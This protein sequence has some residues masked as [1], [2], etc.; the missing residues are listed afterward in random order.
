MPL[1]SANALARLA[2]TLAAMCAFGCQSRS[3]E[4]TQQVVAL[5]FDG[6]P[7]AKPDESVLVRAVVPQTAA[8]RRNPAPQ[9]AR[10]ATG[11]VDGDGRLFL[12]FTWGTIHGGPAPAQHTPPPASGDWLTGWPCQFAIEW[13]NGTQEAFSLDLTRDAATKVGNVTVRVVD[14]LPAR[15]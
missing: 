11:A 13:P 3:V 8:G 7:P 6:L 9:D 15:R 4:M 2:L 12:G 14:I 1:K 5:Q 10:R